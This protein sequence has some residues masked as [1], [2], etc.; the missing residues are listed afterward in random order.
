MA[1]MRVKR[2]LRA[3]EE[4]DFL[5]PV[6]PGRRGALVGQG[7]RGTYPLLLLY[8]EASPPGQD[9]GDRP[10]MVRAPNMFLIVAPMECLD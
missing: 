9:S 7:V 1:S 8:P 4:R 5:S 6:V 3:G 2:E 10:F